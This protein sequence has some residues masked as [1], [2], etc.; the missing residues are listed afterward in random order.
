MEVNK[1]WMKGGPDWL[2][3]KSTTIQPPTE[4]IQLGSPI[5]PLQTLT[6]GEGEE[7]PKKEG[8]G[9]RKEDGERDGRGD[10]D[11]GGI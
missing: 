2:R 8:D 11:W 10:D 3:T 9:E 4:Q 1:Y 6:P 5:I 7:P